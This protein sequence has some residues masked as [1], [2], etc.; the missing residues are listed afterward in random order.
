MTKKLATI[1]GV[2]V[3]VF[4]AGIMWFA[5]FFESAP[6]VLTVPDVTSPW[7]HKHVDFESSVFFFK[8]ARL[9]ICIRGEL[10]GTAQFSYGG[11]P[12]VIGPGTVLIDRTSP[13]WWCEWCEISYDPIDVKGGR[14]EI[15]VNID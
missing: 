12:Q 4:L 2:T 1:L 13:E 9:T 15:E 5:V 10:D 6:A 8:G 3:A 14:L 7:Q 11:H